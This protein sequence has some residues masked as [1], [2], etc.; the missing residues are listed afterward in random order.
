MVIPKQIHYGNTSI[1]YTCIA[2]ECTHT[3]TQAVVELDL[4]LVKQ[5]TTAIC[6]R[7]CGSDREVMALVACRDLPGCKLL[8]YHICFDRAPYVSPRVLLDHT[9]CVHRHQQFIAL[10]P[11]QV[12]SYRAASSRPVNPLA[13]D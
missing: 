1:R 7:H 3:T 10:V 12:S 8:I 6:H 11:L 13:A 2:L 5:Y 4:Y 9:I